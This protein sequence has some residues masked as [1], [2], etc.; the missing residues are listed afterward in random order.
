[1][2]YCLRAN[3]LPDKRTTQQWH[4]YFAQISIQWYHT[5]AL[6]VLGYPKIQTV[7]VNVKRYLIA[8]HFKEDFLYEHCVAG[9]GDS[10]G[11]VC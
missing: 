9:S 10:S 8:I 4:L 7:S 6:R 5:S 1:M 11:K 3:A 2:K